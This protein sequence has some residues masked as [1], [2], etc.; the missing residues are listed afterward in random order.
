MNPK[1][2]TRIWLEYYIRM[3]QE[4]F[5]M[6]ACVD[7]GIQSNGGRKSQVC[8]PTIVDPTISLYYEATGSVYFVSGRCG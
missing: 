4:L 5:A 1:H 3:R 7:L 2:A 8:S 6:H